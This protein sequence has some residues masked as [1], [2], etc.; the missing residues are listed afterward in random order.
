[1]LIKVKNEKDAQMKSVKEKIKKTLFR[2]EIEKQNDVYVYDKTITN[3]V[4]NPKIL[5]LIQREEDAILLIDCIEKLMQEKKHYS[6]KMR[7]KDGMIGK[8]FVELYSLFPSNKLLDRINEFIYLNFAFRTAAEFAQK[9]DEFN[10]DK[11]EEFCD[12]NKEKIN[13]TIAFYFIKNV[14]GANIEFWEDLILNQYDWVMYIKYC[15]EIEKANVAKFER[16]LILDENTFGITEFAMKVERANLV[17]L[18]L[19]L[20][21]KNKLKSL[22]P[23]FEIFAGEKVVKRLVEEIVDSGDL[24]LCLKATRELELEEYHKSL[25][26]FAIKSLKMAE[27][28]NKELL[29]EL[30]LQK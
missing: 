12:Q 16:R 3:Q 7:E 17:T 14:K 10:T 6:F 28:K 25:L 26:D 19:Y 18:G 13:Y 20:I 27:S 2:R 23:Y 15:K 9:I 24:N 30:I 8:L 21:R 5:K 4:I 22:L 11:F 29:E 1:M